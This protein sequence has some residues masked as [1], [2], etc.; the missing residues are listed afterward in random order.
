MFRCTRSLSNVRKSRFPAANTAKYARDRREIFEASREFGKFTS[1][2]RHGHLNF[3]RNFVEALVSPISSRIRAD[4]RGRAPCATWP[5][6]FRQY[7]PS[8]RSGGGTKISA[9]FV[10]SP[11]VGTELDISD[12]W[13][14]PQRSTWRVDFAAELSGALK[15]LSPLGRRSGKFEIYILGARRTPRKTRSFKR[16]PRHRSVLELENGNSLQRAVSC[17]PDVTRHF[18]A[19]FTLY[20]VLYE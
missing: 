7:W 13:A 9:D 5:I 14:N 3:S 17:P 11:P 10:L 16:W 18:P 6:F 2:S 19:T 8:R 15:A 1:A 20:L 4:A 12:E